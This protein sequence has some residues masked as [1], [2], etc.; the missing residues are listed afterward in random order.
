MHVIVDGQVRVSGDEHGETVLGPGEAIGMLTLL[1]RD[2]NG[3]EAV[4]DTDT[5]T[6]ALRA[7]DLFDAFESDFGLLYSQTR[8]LATETLRLRRQVPAGTYLPYEPYEEEAP[9]G[10]WS[11]LWMGA[12][13]EV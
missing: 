11:V 6:L 12:I 1:A 8:Y 7:D 5:V 2:D 13:A 4:A 9:V 10:W 3:I